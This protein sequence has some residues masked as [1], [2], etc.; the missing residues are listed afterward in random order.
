MADQHSG[1]SREELLRYVT[2]CLRQ[3]KSMKASSKTLSEA[4]KKLIDSLKLANNELEK[5]INTNRAINARNADLQRQIEMVM[6][7]IE[8][9]VNTHPDGERLVKV[10]NHRITKKGHWSY[11]YEDEERFID[12]D[13]PKFGGKDDV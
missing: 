5:A 13:D 11:P 6:V 7:F 4:N 2:H 12:I 10:W 3:I 9:F 1:M 8:E